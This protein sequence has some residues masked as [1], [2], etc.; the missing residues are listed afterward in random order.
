MKVGV[1]GVNKITLFCPEEVESHTEG[2]GN[3]AGGITGK[4]GEEGLRLRL[5]R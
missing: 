5:T 4:K 2:F 1:G 3:H